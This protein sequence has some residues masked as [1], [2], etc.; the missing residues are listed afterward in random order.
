[1]D[2]FKNEGPGSVGDDLEKGSKLMEGYGQN[3]KFFE[4]QRISLGILFLF[5]FISS[6]HQLQS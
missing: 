4:E 5:D 6:T 2:K 3:I 1:M